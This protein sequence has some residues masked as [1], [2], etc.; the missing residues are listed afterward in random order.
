MLKVIVLVALAASFTIA[1]AQLCPDNDADYK[2]GDLKLNLDVPSW[3]ECA[4]GCSKEAEC[5]AFTYVQKTKCCYL[6]KGDAKSNKVAAPGLISGDNTCRG[7][8]CNGINNGCCTKATPCLEGDGDCDNDGECAS[9]L[10]CGMDNCPWG[11]NDDC[12]IKEGTLRCN[13]INNGCCKR[14]SPC[15]EGD[16]DCDTDAECAEGLICGKDNCPWGDNDDCCMKAP[17]TVKSD[18][19]FPVKQVQGGFCY[20]DT[21]AVPTKSSLIGTI[22]TLGKSYEISF[23]VYPNS[24]PAG[25]QWANLFHFTKGGNAAAYGDRNPAMWFYTGNKWLICSA[26]NGQK[27]Q[28]FTITGKPLKQW[29]SV[30]IKQHLE[31][32]DYV[33]VIYFDGVLVK[34]WTNTKPQE[35]KNVKLY[36]SDP[37]Y[38][39]ADAYIKNL[40]FI[41]L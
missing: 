24:M 16:G 1:Q 13:G 38:I 30:Q 23:D 40:C 28:C 9:G 14:I 29:Y 31:N 20:F 12:C 15:I 36:T 41:A 37:W 27:N 25:N 18:P 5:T 8:R 32:G 39:A 4:Q 35:F 33:Y 34:T 17:I 6:K 7:L 11:D 22:P 2:G 21:Q 10:I 19:K 26:I 3:R